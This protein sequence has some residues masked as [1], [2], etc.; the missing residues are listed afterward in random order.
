MILQK[1]LDRIEKSPTSFHVVENLRQE[2]LEAGFTELYEK[3]AWTIVPG[4]R[5][6]VTRNGSSMIAFVMP[7]EEPQGFMII[8]AHPDSPALRIKEYPEIEVPGYYVKLNV[9]K[10]GG[11]LL[12][13]W[14][15]R[16]LSVAGRVVLREE[17]PDGSEQLRTCLVNID[18]DLLMLPSLAIHMDREANN[19]HA[20]SVQKDMLPL[21]GD[22]AAKGNFR[23][24]IAE[25]CGAEEKDVLGADLFI[26]CRN[27]PVIW[28]AD[29]EFFS[30]PRL[31][32]QECVWT[33]WEA[34]STCRPRTHVA[35][36]A[37][38]DNEE[39]GSGT[40]QG[41]AST[42]LA[43]VLRRIVLA[44]G[45]SEEQYCRLLASSFMASE[46]NAH[47]FHPNHGEKADP[48]NRPAMNGG[49]VI[50]HS[51]NQ[52]YATDAVAEAVCRMI[53]GKAGVPIQVFTNHSDRPGGSTLGNISNTQVSL[54]TVDIGLAQLAMHSA[55]ETAGTKDPEY[56]VRFAE[57]FYTSSFCR[58]GDRIVL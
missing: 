6:F 43:D 19:G 22:A 47:A 20:W 7:E 36:Q 52:K 42:F 41:A 56:M 15:D 49:I 33:S 55:F 2:M 30:A 53:A 44:R 5:Y 1:M 17:L 28:G 24:T 31:D 45:G 50:K 46:D 29:E 16:P 11:A 38:L 40:K 21:F 35:V 51:A 27:K 23:K 18:R 58:E 39:V 14:F 10:Y 8:A 3:G 25:A 37:V 26:Y 4:G 32:D 54:D 57:S 48:V 9:E 12:S 13:T 34:L